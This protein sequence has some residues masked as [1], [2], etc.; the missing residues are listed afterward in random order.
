MLSGHSAWCHQCAKFR[1]VCSQ[2]DFGFS[3]FLKQVWA[4]W[5]AKITC[6]YC[7]IAQT[8][9][10]NLFVSTSLWLRY[11]RNKCISWQSLTSRSWELSVSR[12]SML[13]RSGWPIFWAKTHW[14]TCHLFHLLMYYIHS[15][16]SIP[17]KNTSLMNFEDPPVWWSLLCCLVQRL[18]QLSEATGGPKRKTKHMFIFSFK[19]S[20]FVTFPGIV[21]GRLR[22]SWSSTTWSSGP[23][24]WTSHWMPFM[25]TVSSRHRTHHGW[26]C[27]ITHCLQKV[28]CTGFRGLVTKIRSP[29]PR[30]PR[31]IPMCVLF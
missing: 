28:S 18:A 31:K 17:Y 20:V 30:W 15:L 21:P 7:A 6:L 24:T 29:R 9:E 22:T 12:T 25:A 16:I 11:L 1:P 5:I 4:N 27:V 23:S 26:L 19:L 2:G 8:F 13:M 3:G 10:F 14:E